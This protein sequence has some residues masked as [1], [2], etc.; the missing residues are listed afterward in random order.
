MVRI[1]PTGSHYDAGDAQ[2]AASHGNAQPPQTGS[3]RPQ[4]AA[5]LA[6]LARQRRSPSPA[7]TPETQKRPASPDNTDDTDI[8]GPATKR[9]RLNAVLRSP[10]AAD[11]AVNLHTSQISAIAATSP[12]SN[13]LGGKVLDAPG[14]SLHSSVPTG[15]DAIRLAADIQKALAPQHG[16]VEIFGYHVTSEQNAAD[17]RS[18]GFSSEKNQGLAGGVSGMNIDGPGLYT[19]RNP[20]NSYVMPDRNNV[21]YAVVVPKDIAFK[22]ASSGTRH[23]WDAASHAATLNDGDFMDSAVG[24][25]KINPAAISKVGLVPVAHIPPSMSKEQLALRADMTR[26]KSALPR[27]VTD[28]LHNWVSSQIENNHAVQDIEAEP[29]PDKRLDM[30]QA[31]ATSLAGRDDK[32]AHASQRLL[33][34]DLKKRF[35]P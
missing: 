16:P 25:R 11:D 23:T 26:D 4:G 31:V 12:G 13:P 29:D 27:T 17:I 3:A 30:I 14:L 24:E 15:G 7:R 8:A 34:M 10:S 28:E 9:M 22:Q 19:S 6:G 32:H 5:E 35:M 1:D 33:M 18:Q 20:S 21:M 2:Q